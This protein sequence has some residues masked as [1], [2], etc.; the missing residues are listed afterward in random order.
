[1]KTIKEFIDSVRLE[2]TK[3]NWPKKQEVVRLTAIVFIISGIVAA[4]VGGLDYLFL[5]LLELIVSQQ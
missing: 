5:K 2:L 4:Y 3:V 1:M